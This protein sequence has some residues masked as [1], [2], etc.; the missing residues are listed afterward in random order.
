MRWS[1]VHIEAIGYEIPEERVR[2]TDLEARLAPLYDALRLQPGQLEALTGIRERRFWP[3]GQRMAACATKAARKA[4]AQSGV[5]A[6]D[7]GAVIYAAVCRDD[8]E[9]ATACEVAHALGT[10]PDAWIF[11]LSN[12]CLGVM[13]GMVE[14]ANR[15][16]LGQIRAG[17][18]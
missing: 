10:S 9:P 12:A 14:I 18:V 4:L 1:R 16:E 6:E 7:L 3:P 13:N 17:L 11:D 5:K 2:S 15:I 8:L